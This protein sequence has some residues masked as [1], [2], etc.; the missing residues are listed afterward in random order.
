MR[1][2]TIAE[3]DGGEITAS[4]HEILGK[5][6]ELAPSG[7]TLDCL[8][9]GPGSDTLA[10]GL[11][12]RGADR[13]LVAEHPGF[14]DYR[15]TPFVRAAAEV[16]KKQ[17][18]DLVL[19]PSTFRGKEMAA[20]LAGLLDCGLAVDVVEIANTG[21]GFRFERPCFGGNRLIE[22]LSTSAPVVAA[23]RPKAFPLPAEQPGRQGEVEKVDLAP[24]PD[25]IERVR[26][27]EF[28]PGGGDG[29]V[30]LQDA[31]VVVSG[32]RGL[33]KP[34]NFSLVRDLAQVLGAAV[35]VDSIRPPGGADRSH[36][37]PA[38]L[39][40]LW[41]F[42]SHPAPGRH[43]HLRRHRGH[44]QGSRS[45]HL[46]GGDLRH[47]RRPLRGVA[48]AHPEAQGTARQLASR[49]RSRARLAP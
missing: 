19:L 46:Q 45:S 23:V 9:L 8:V 7:G 16:A 17:Q 27:I 15:F 20:G 31:E 14:K 36:G 40:R 47:R 42:G 25:E 12:A 44:Q 21:Q 24:A 48:P 11:F 32:G 30:N 13:V 41:D 33:Q 28:L 10:P 18:A 22:V 2:L 38:A 29:Q 43:A 5:A 3:I 39:H 6:R 4:T 35:G 26:L 37:E 1:I 34:E 49:P